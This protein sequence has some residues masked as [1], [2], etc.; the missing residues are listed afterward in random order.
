MD[1]QTLERDI[2]D[3]DASTRMAASVKLGSLIRGG[4]LGRTVTEEVNNHVHTTYSF[5]P[6]EPAAAAYAAWK[7][8]LGIVGSIDHDSIGAAAEMLESGRNIGIATT[9]GFELRVSFL[10]TPLANRKIN[11]PDSEGIVY[12][13]VHGVAKQHIPA[14]ASF[15][16]PL[17]EVRNKRNRAQVEALQALVGRYG[18]DLDFERDVLPLSRF[19][20]GGSVTERHILYAMAGQSIR[21]FGKGEKLV[22][23]LLSSLG[24]PLSS[25]LQSLLLDEN[26]P[27][28]AYDLLGIY[29]S[30]FL[31]RFFIQPGRDEC[32]DVRK[33][34][35]FSHSIG[36]IAAY[37]YLG[38]IAE[39]VTGDKK[40]EQ[41]EDSFLVELMDLLVDIGFPAVTYMPPRNTVQQMLRLQ[42]LAKERGL[43]EISG[44]DINSSRQSMNCPELLEPAARHLVDSAWALVAH[45]KLSSVD[46]KL[47]LFHPQNPFAEK[48]LQTRLEHYAR[49]GRSMDCSNP[50]AIIEKF[51]ETV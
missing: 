34:V 12:M 6:Y 28:Y 33:V 26:N 32:M 14:V 38:D 48:S 35:D 27:H 20:E 23:F 43:M 15:L 44:V 8:G 39:S 19:S 36:A 1:I 16:K 47:G 11:N 30:N 4:E 2:N 37:A 22:R 29:K 7:A 9:V 17:Q 42:S 45:E 51:Q 18:F 50:Y 46:A 40:A 49:L 3:R 24:L 31:P 10:D 25:K 13:C 41:F 5:S 21:M